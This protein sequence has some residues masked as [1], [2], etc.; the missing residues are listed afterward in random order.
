MTRVG[1]ASFHIIS[2]MSGQR[3]KEPSLARSDLSRPQV[4]INCAGITRDGMLWKLDDAKWNSV[5]DVNLKG[6]FNCI[7]AF[8]KP[9]LETKTGEPSR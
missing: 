4:L 9:L 1:A 7:Q 5:I 8:A 2:T 3:N 6:P